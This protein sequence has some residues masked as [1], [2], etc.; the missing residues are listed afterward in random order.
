MTDLEGDVAMGWGDAPGWGALVFSAGALWVSLKAQRDGKRA[1]DVA[2]ATLARQVAAEEESARPRVEL[3]IEHGQKDAYRLRNNGTASARDIV[4][5]DEELPYVFGLK[6]GE[7]V[8]LERGEAVAFLM[9][10]SIPPQLFAR[11]DGQDEWVPVRI[12]PKR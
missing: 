1:A 8:S 3:R 9:A 12:P 4:F 10:G 2:E 6:G 5:K 11:W 7:K